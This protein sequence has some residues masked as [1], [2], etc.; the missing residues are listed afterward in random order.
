MCVCV[1]GGGGGQAGTPGIV[2]MV[3]F[4]GVWMLWVVEHGNQFV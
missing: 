3:V 1:V 4:F 2:I